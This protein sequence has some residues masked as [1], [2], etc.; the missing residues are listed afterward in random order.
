MTDEIPRQKFAIS[1]GEKVRTFMEGRHTIVSLGEV[2]LVK[3]PDVP[4]D[5][6]FWEWMR[7]TWR[8]DQGKPA[9]APLCAGARIV[10]DENGEGTLTIDESLPDGVWIV[11]RADKTLRYEGV[12]GPVRVQSHAEKEEDIEV[13]PVAFTFETRK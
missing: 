1:M 9:D 7:D 12:T 2:L 4:A 3:E 8:E 5:F 11:T 6:S 13:S 10:V